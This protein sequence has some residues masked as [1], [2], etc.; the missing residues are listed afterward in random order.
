MKRGYYF[1]LPE[2]TIKKIDEVYPYNGYTS[3]TDYVLK[4]LENSIRKKMEGKKNERKNSSR[5]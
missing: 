1:I 2:E 5:K 4:I 3:R